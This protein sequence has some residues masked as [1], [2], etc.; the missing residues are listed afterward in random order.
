[1]TQIG[2]NAKI[3]ATS[4]KMLGWITGQ[5]FCDL[6]IILLR[7]FMQGEVSQVPNY[8]VIAETTVWYIN[9]H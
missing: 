4:V 9:T 6:T 3:S 7:D 5:V 8:L 1:M 2:Y